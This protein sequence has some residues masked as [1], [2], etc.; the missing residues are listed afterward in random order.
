MPNWAWDS[1]IWSGFIPVSCH[2]LFCFCLVFRSPGPRPTPALSVMVACV[3]RGELGRLLLC[4]RGGG[5]IWVDVLLEADGREVGRVLETVL[6]A[7]TLDVPRD[8]LADRGASEAISAFKFAVANSCS[9]EWA[10]WTRGCRVIAD[11]QFVH[12][13]TEVTARVRRSLCGECRVQDCAPQPRLPKNPGSK[14]KQLS[15]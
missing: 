4:G 6:W 13:A 5:S 1:D 12:A 14:S 15:L 7:C 2:T 8:D 11:L 10:K 9:S 3:G